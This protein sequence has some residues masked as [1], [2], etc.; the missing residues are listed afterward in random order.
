MTR[1]LYQSH[2]QHAEGNLQYLDFIRLVDRL[3]TESHP[4]IPLYATGGA[5]DAIY[6]SI[7][8]S[9]QVRRPHPNEPKPRIREEIR[10]APHEQAILISAQRFQNIVNFSVVTE[11]DPHTAEELIEAFEEF[12]LEMTPIFKRMGVSE[13]VYARR[14]PDN[15]ENRQGEDTTMRTVSYM[16]T[17]EKISAIS[18]SKINN[19]I[20]HARMAITQEPPYFIASSTTSRIT[21]YG[22]SLQEGDVI[23]FAEKPTES[24]P[25]GLEIGATYYVKSVVELESGREYVITPVMNGEDSVEITTSGTGL[26]TRPV[27]PTVPMTLEDDFQRASAG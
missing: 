21:T 13:F 26:I 10:T 22:M 6:P 9:L 1:P 4:E 5:Q 23:S 2:Y 25:Y 17:T 14:M 7:I 8:Y 20:V 19:F 24:F 12:M 15:E 16:L 11:N 27:L 18:E 3:W